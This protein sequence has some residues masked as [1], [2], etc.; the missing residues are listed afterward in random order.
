MGDLIEQPLV[1]IGIPCYNRPESLRRTLESI[2]SQSYTN[3]EIIVSDNCSPLEEEIAQV[4]YTFSGDLRIHYVRHNKNHGP[5]FNFEFVLDQ[6]NGMFFMWCGDDDF[7]SVDYIK[8]SIK[9]LNRHTDYVSVCGAPYALT[10]SGLISKVPGNVGSFVQESGIKR[11]YATYAATSGRLINFYGIMRIEVIKRID[12]RNSFAGDRFTL[13]AVAFQGKIKMIE[14]IKFCRSPGISANSNKQFHQEMQQLLGIK[15]TK[16]LFGIRF[17]M[18]VMASKDIIKQSSVY[19]SL[20]KIETV[21]LMVMV[22]VTSIKDTLKKFIFQNFFKRVTFGVTGKIK[23]F[24]HKLLFFRKKANKPQKDKVAFWGWWSGKNLGD[25]WIKEILKFEFPT[26]IFIDCSVAEFDNYGMV[27]CGGG[28]LFIH[29]V[30]ECWRKPINIPYGLIGLGAEFPHNSNSAKTLSEHAEFFFVRDSYSLRC[31]DLN[32]SFLSRD[33]TFLKPLKWLDVINDSVCLLSWRFDVLGL[34]KSHLN[35][36]NYIGE[37]TEKEIWDNLLSKLFK[38]VVQNDFSTTSSDI[39]IIMDGVGFVVSARFHGIVAAIQKGI[40]CIGIDVCPKIRTLLEDCGLSDYCI[41]L[42]E[43]DKLPS[44]IK[45]AQQDTSKIRS[46][47]KNYRDNAN[48]TIINH[49]DSVRSKIL[50]LGFKP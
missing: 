34:K 35:F 48:R 27:I 9:F 43:V 13:A 44:L 15:K 38:S 20:T 28:G 24:V 36:D 30:M 49:F 50:E 29:D 3:L 10:Q 40:P 8:T 21:Y 33:V 45:K 46:K 32:D 41:K 6:A 42:S 1:S 16:S 23:R 17:E 22:F 11:C 14:S 18:A 47:Q 5:A 26:S 39:S 12:L 4:M 7:L 2:T 25:N 19:K 31:M 37:Q